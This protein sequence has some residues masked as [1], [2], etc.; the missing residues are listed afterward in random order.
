MRTATGTPLAG[1][2]ALIFL[3][4]SS[5]AIADKDEEAAN[6]ELLLQTQQ[7]TATANLLQL[8]RSGKF[9]SRNEQRLPGRAQT[10]VYERYINS[11]G[12][13]IPETYINEEFSE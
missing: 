13:P 4:L 2:L 3:C 1:M 12:H 11:F 8:Q 10:K 9:A 5:A 6:A 7:T